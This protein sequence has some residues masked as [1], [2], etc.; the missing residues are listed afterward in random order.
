MT[1]EDERV[2][3]LVVPRASVVDSFV[4]WTIRHGDDAHPD[5]DRAA[6]ERAQADPEGFVETLVSDVRERA[7]R[8]AGWVPSTHLWWIEGCEYLGRLQVRHRLKRLPPRRGRSHRLLHRSRAPAT[9]SRQRNVRGGAARNFRARHRL[10]ARDLR[11]RQHRLPPRD[12][13]PRRSA[14]GRPARDAALLGPDL[15]EQSGARL[16]LAGLLLHFP[17]RKTIRVQ[18]V[19]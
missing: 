16:L 17:C 9:R 18:A 8:P 19:P 2:P 6:G 12:R 14:Q 10:C 4:R 7:P 15:L 11:E 13:A 3:E 1:E 5:Y